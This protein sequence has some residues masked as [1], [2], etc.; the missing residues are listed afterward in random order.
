[1]DEKQTQATTEALSSEEFWNRLASCQEQTFY[2][3]KKLPK[4]HFVDRQ[5]QVL[6]R[7]SPGMENLD[8]LDQYLF[9]KD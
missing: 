1:M 7:L 9:G 6:L 2:T 8:L 4:G 3:E 5:G